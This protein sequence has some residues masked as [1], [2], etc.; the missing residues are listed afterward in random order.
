M[1]TTIVSRAHCV[2]DT[3]PAGALF[4]MT[5]ESKHYDFCFTKEQIE[6]YRAQSRVAQEHRVS[7]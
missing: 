1:E 4:Q 7:Q 6:A 2:I 5:L 3:V